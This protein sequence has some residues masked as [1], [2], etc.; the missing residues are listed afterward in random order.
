MLNIS[1]N[2]VVAGQPVVFN[3]SVDFDFKK[4]EEAYDKRVKEFGWKWDD[5]IQSDYY[6]KQTLNI[7]RY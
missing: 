3:L 5:P 7:L 4:I 6:S 2:Q 1:K